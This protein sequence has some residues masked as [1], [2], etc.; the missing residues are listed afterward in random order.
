MAR[1]LGI[2]FHRAFND[3][4]F[5][6]GPFIPPSNPANESEALASE[7]EKL[8]AEVHKTKLSLE[9]A[10]ALAE[11][12]A[13][14][15]LNLEERL[16]KDQEERAAWQGLA[17]DAER[18]LNAHL[19][20]VQAE[21]QAKP[22]EQL[23]LIADQAHDAAEHLDLSESDTRRIIDG[24]LRAA[25]WEA[26]SLELTYQAGARPQKGRNLAISEWPTANGPADY[27]LFS[28]LDVLGVVEAKR[29][30]RDVMASIEQSKRYSEGF[31][32]H[33]DEQLVGGPWG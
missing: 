25:G 13:R 30:R 5:K 32:V 24:Q 33:G 23:K 26:N 14:Q 20:Q 12:E 19:T 15:R 9:Q 8:R 31:E 18:K 1:E 17:E 28:G 2:W 11:Q 7:I 29:K 10:Q 27:V 16:L 6:P 22:A 3:K 4:A 21:A